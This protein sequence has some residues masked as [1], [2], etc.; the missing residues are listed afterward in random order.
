MVVLALIY[1]VAQLK[2]LEQAILLL[3]EQ[4]EQEPQIMKVSL[5]IMVEKFNQQAVI[6][7]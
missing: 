3:Q 1:M 7:I 5:L 4:E 6:S 2:R